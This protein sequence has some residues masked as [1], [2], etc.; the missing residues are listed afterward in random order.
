MNHLIPSPEIQEERLKVF[1]YLR[2]LVFTKLGAHIF[3][4]G[5]FLTNTYLPNGDIDVT[6]FFLHQEDESWF[7]R[8]NE[9]LCMTAFEGSGYLS[10]YVSNPIAGDSN[11]EKS[12]HNAA[13]SKTVTNETR[14]TINNVSFVNADIKLIKSSINGVSIDLSAN[15]IG[16]IYL[17]YFFELLDDFVGQNHLFKRSILLIKAWCTYES[18]KYSRGAG[19]VVGSK[20]GRLSTSSLNVMTSWIFNLHGKKIKHPLQALYYFLSFYSTFDWNTYTITIHGPLSAR[21]LS[22]IKYERSGS[23]IDETMNAGLASS[24]EHFFPNDLLDCMKQ[25]YIEGRESCISNALFPVLQQLGYTAP[26]PHNPQSIESNKNPESTIEN[27]I[28][29]SESQYQQMLQLP[30][31]IEAQNRF[32]KSWITSS[33]FGDA[34]TF[35][36][37]GLINVMNPVAP[38][39]NISRAVDMYG[40][41][42]IQCAFKEGFIALRLFIEKMDFAGRDDSSILSHEKV[43]L[44]QYLINMN[45]SQGIE[46]TRSNDH[47]GPSFFA[48][49]I[50]EFMSNT[51]TNIIL[52]LLCGTSSSHPSR[53]LVATSTNASNLTKSINSD[54]NEDS[55]KSQNRQVG[56]N[57]SICKEDL[58]V[59]KSPNCF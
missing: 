22:E 21:D 10:A 24:E 52:P 23:L 44:A 46:S 26:T 38:K 27:S 36:K 2:A 54:S 28:P 30:E 37:R 12:L 20:E 19:S 43:S 50:S 47:T 34:A 51:T 40:F 3:P 17:Q 7:V 31:V 48:S 58:E 59:N 14:F 45:S 41:K 39:N 29:D 4:V 6:A 13:D 5:S 42:A 33:A 57:L 25:R 53:R 49:A 16:A 32:V 1:E 18:Y 9:I 56:D 35:Y 15:Q 11:T 8:V 55:I